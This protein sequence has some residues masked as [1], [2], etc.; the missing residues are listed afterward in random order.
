M[1]V[2]AWAF[3]VQQ[4]FASA[5]VLA[6][7]ARCMGPLRSSPWRMMAASLLTALTAMAA[8]PLPAPGRILAALLCAFTPLAAWPDAPRRFRPRL[9]VLGCVFPL[10]LTGMLRLTGF[11]PGILALP[12]GCALMMASARIQRSGLPL[13]RCI[14]VEVT[15]GSR[16]AVLTALVDTG[17]LLR[18]SVTGLPVI[19]ISRRAAARLTRLPE[20]G[21][22]LP[23]MRL[24]PVRTVSGVALM[25]I[26]RPDRLRVRSGDAWQ[27]Q[28][29]LIGLSPGGGEGFQA[30]MPASLLC[31]LPPPDAAHP[32]QAFPHQTPTTGG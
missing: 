23:G 1:Q 24:M 19:V 21:S 6:A 26:L 9:V 29:A 27:Q 16:R 30:L 14:S 3:L 8:A 5:C 2:S 32:R 12:L 10:L 11:L 7:I 4:F 20:D 18:D 22:L 31:D 13:P 17:N 25:T 15:V 28:S